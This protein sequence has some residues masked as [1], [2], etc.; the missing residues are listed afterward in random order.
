MQARRVCVETLPSF[1]TFYLTTVDRRLRRPVITRDA[2]ARTKK[3]NDFDNYYFELFNA[4]DL[5][6]LVIEYPPKTRKQNLHFEFPL[7]LLSYPRLRIADLVCPQIFNDVVHHFLI[8][9]W[10]GV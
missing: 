4:A 9:S 6:M 1:P 10:Q 3:E 7:E 2:R 5:K 8:N